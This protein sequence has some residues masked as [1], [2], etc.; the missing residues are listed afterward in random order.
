M[1]TGCGRCE[2]NHVD[3]IYKT[4]ALNSVK[5]GWVI[6]N[7]SYMLYAKPERRLLQWI[8]AIAQPLLRGWGPPLRGGIVIWLARALRALE[9]RQHVIGLHDDITVILF[10][11]LMQFRLIFR[12]LWLCLRNS[13]TSHFFGPQKQSHMQRRI[14]DTLHLIMNY[15]CANRIIKVCICAMWKC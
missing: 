14:F 15:Y 1:Q 5:I 2:L 8:I 12:L 7:Y 6:D 10:P 4:Q 9:A 13:N 11:C 3:D